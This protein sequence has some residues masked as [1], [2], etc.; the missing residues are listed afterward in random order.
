MLERSLGV[1][2]DQVTRGDQ[3]SGHGVGGDPVQS[4][5]LSADLGREL[6]CLDIGRNP[7]RSAVL[8]GGPM[9]GLCSASAIGAR[10]G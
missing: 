6:L 10:S 9:L 1:V 7:R 4:A 5:E 3:V 8:I 2:V